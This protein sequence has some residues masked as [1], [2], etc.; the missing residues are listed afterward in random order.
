MH[1]K[2]DLRFLQERFNFRSL[3]TQEIPQAFLDSRSQPSPHAPLQDLLQHGHFRRAAELASTELSQCPAQ[4]A[5]TIFQLLYTRLACLVLISR[6]DLA[7]QEAAP[8]VEF[9][10]GSPPGA[11]ELMAY[12]P[13]ELQL[14][15][16]RLQAIGASDAGRRGIMGLYALAGE[17]RSQIRRAR[18]HGS[19]SDVVLWTGRLADLGLKVA[20]T[21]V[22]MGEL[23]TAL[24]HLDTMDNVH[25]DTIAYRKALIRLRFGDVQGADRCIEQLGDSKRKLSLRIVSEFAKD[26]IESAVELCRTMFDDGDPV[27]ASNLAT[28]LLY[29]GH[30][31]EARTIMQEL[32]GRRPAFAGL[33]FNLSTI[34]ELCT[35]QARDRKKS[36]VDQVAEKMPSFEN[37]GWERPSAEFKL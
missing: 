9:F 26:R 5:D 29:T 27:F 13:W 33:L 17:S 25:V 23:D 16:V 10:A 28:C 21:L 22:E 1:M 34:Y 3:S 19:Q 20:D 11:S 37:G 36:L 32:L 8:I 35:A 18:E 14:L 2:V 7:S 30:V 24:R 15:V 6:P 12:V 4:E 31:A